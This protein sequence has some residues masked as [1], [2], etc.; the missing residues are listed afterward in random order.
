[1][2]AQH[3]REAVDRLV[4]AVKRNRG[5]KKDTEAAKGGNELVTGSVTGK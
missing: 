5:P 1:V 2:A 3:K 4:G